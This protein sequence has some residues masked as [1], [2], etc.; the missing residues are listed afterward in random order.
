MLLEAEFLNLRFILVLK[1]LKTNDLG[2]RE[3]A[4]STVMAENDI[5]DAGS[6]DPDPAKEL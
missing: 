5:H 4:T 3:T 2:Y 6:N 1:R